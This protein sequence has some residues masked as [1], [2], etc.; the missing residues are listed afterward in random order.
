MKV[1]T[2]IALPFTVPAVMLSPNGR[3]DGYPEDTVP[4]AQNNKTY[5]ATRELRQGCGKYC[6]S[7]VHALFLRQLS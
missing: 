2:Y 3:A 4:L 7:S 6:T 1:M 5:S